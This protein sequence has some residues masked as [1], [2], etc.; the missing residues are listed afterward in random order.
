MKVLLDT[1]VLVDLE[2]KD[3][4][5]LGLV[6]KLV[7]ENVPM[8]ISAIT[9]SEILAGAY[10]TKNSE[11]SVRMAKDM[12]SEFSFVDVNGQVA[13]TAAKVLAYRREVAK[14]IAYTDAAIIASFVVS[15]SD[16]LLTSN[17]KDFDFPALGG[18]VYAPKEFLR[19]LKGKK[20]KFVQ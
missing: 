2:R 8:L 6:K 4:E 14:P 3:D 12:L 17:K 18:K 19:A 10:I 20:L 7:S 15:N 16:F 11:Q 9:I 1:T 13:E 5:T